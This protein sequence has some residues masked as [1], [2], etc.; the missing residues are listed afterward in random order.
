M[1]EPADLQQFES[2]LQFLHQTRG[3]DFTAY[4]RP[5]LIRR[6][7]RRIQAVN[8]STFAALPHVLVERSPASAGAI[9]LVD[10]MRATVQR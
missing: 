5:T 2:S 9:L 1:S 7:T 8:V 6:V 3:F 4:K 10:E